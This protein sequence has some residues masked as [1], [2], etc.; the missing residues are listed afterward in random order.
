MIRNCL[1]LLRCYMD[2]TIAFLTVQII[3]TVLSKIFRMEYN[4]ARNSELEIMKPNLKVAGF[5]AIR[6]KFS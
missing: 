1:G 2:N 6:S 5:A 3:V 4:I